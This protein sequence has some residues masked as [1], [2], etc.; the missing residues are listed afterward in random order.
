MGS[1]SSHPKKR[2]KELFSSFGS[3]RIYDNVSLTCQQ[4]LPWDGGQTVSRVY[5]RDSLF[6]G[7]CAPAH[8]FSVYAVCFVK[9]L[10]YEVRFTT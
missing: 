7:S 9:N 6:V 3:S 8:L 4:V 5:F 2:T 1:F 10:I